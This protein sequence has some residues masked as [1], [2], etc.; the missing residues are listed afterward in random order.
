MRMLLQ[1]LLFALP[2]GALLLSLPAGAEVVDRVV[3]VVGQQVV[4]ASDIRFEEEIAHLDQSPLPFW[5][6]GRVTPLRRLL[7]AAV[8]RS[9]AG[10][11]A[12]Y[13]PPDEAVRDRLEVLRGRF[14]SRADWEEF[15]RRWGLDEAGLLS[16]LRRRM[17]VE[18]YLFRN[19]QL[20]P[21]D[22][23]AWLEAADLLLE[24]LRLR[25]DVRMIPERPHP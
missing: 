13:A 18:R 8:I 5:D 7:E 10:D 6:A 1:R 9:S 19:L 14:V 24:R 21:D 3:A 25:Y 17:V 4:L 20:S 23:E 15:Q 2:L 12:L 16:V 11:L 22:R